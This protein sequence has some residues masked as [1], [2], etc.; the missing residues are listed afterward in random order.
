MIG[1][2]VKIL[3]FALSFTFL[4]SWGYVKQQRQMEE[5]LE[6]LQKK[7]KRR[8]RKA[9][10]KKEILTRK[11]IEALVQTTSISLFWSKKKLQVTDPSK[12]A[13]Q[14]LTEM[15]ENG[16]LTLLRRKGFNEYQL[17]KGA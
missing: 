1:F 9:F 5:M 7:A 3:L 14:I 12:L 6:K 13:N 8:I 10:R 4:L 11:D 15:K 17:T 16:E 2:L